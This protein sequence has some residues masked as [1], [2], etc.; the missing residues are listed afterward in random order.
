MRKFHITQMNSSLIL[1]LLFVTNRCTW[2]WIF[3]LGGKCFSSQIWKILVI[4]MSS[5]PYF[6]PR[7]RPRLELPF[8]INVWVN[9][10]I[11]CC[12]EFFPGVYFGWLCGR[13]EWL[14]MSGITLIRK[15]TLAGSLV[16]MIFIIY[17][18]IFIGRLVFKLLFDLMYL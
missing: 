17:S 15:L 10:D 6:G 14:A 1:L 5:P 3:Y 7:N 12:K 8:C 16:L 11:I 2:L 13:G 18:C 4:L 9:Y